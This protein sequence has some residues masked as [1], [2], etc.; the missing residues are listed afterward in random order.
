MGIIV[1]PT[2]EVPLATLKPSA[3]SLR[4][5]GGD[6][7]RQARALNWINNNGQPMAKPE[8]HRKSLRL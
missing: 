3:W 5:V 1:R 6:S 7:C 8:G 2:L 4:G